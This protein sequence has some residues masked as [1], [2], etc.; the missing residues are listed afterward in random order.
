MTEI[1]PLNSP[2][3]ESVG[4]QGPNVRDIDVNTDT[5]S[6]AD[7]ALKPFSSSSILRLLTIFALVRIIVKFNIV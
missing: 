6:T 5:I 3:K 7:M 1:P 2:H 4:A